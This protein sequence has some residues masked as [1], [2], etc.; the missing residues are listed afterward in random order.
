[1]PRPNISLSQVTDILQKNSNQSADFNALLA[2]FPF[3]EVTLRTSLKRL[4]ESKVV[5]VDRN[6]KPYTYTLLP[7]QEG[8]A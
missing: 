6:T 3:S 7:T 8:A 4:L 1:M 2:D 5:S